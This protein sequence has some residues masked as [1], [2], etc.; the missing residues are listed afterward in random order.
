[1]C[2]HNSITLLREA[3]VAGFSGNTKKEKKELTRSR[4]KVHHFC[5]AVPSN[6]RGQRGGPT[7][8]GSEE[9]Y[10]G[11]ALECRANNL[12]ARKFKNIQRPLRM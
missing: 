5:P 2:T 6:Y 10:F 4:K 1:M 3:A 9:S 12:T 7:H 8:A 11:V